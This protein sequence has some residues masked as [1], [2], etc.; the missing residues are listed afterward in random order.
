MIYDYQRVLRIR[1][2]QDP[3][4]KRRLERAAAEGRRIAES[5][6]SRLTQGPIPIGRP[7]TPEDVVAEADRNYDLG[8]RHGRDETSSPSSALKSEISRILL[9][10][11]NG[12]E[13]RYRRDGYIRWGLVES[14]IHTAIDAEIPTSA[15]T[16]QRT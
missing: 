10:A 11:I 12:S 4:Y 6:N 8:R 3:E 14:E 1:C 13:P 16:A 9:S 15:A 5:W 2:A 7:I